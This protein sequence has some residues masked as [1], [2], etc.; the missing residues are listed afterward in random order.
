M[1]EFMNRLRTMIMAGLV[2]SFVVS[3]AREAGEKCEEAEQ[4]KEGLVCYQDKCFM[5][6]E[7]GAECTE[8]EA[9]VKGLVC[10]QEK[11]FK[12]REPG[13][14]CADAAECL[15]GL[16]CYR[17]KCF[18]L[19][20]PGAECTDAAE[21]REG[22][23]CYQDKCFKLRDEGAD[24]AAAGEC[25]E[26]LVCYGDKC[27]KLRETGADCADAGACLEGLVCY[28]DK[29]FELREAGAACAEAGECKEGLVCYQDKCF[30]RREAGAECAEA[31]ECIEGL[32]CNKGKCFKLRDA[33]GDCADGAECVEG[34]VCFDGR[35]MTEEDKVVA[36]KE[37]KE[38]EA[39]AK[40]V[41]RFRDGFSPENVKVH[42]EAAALVAEGTKEYKLIFKR[43]KDGKDLHGEFMKTVEIVEQISKVAGEGKMEEL[44]ALTAEGMALSFKGFAVATNKAVKHTNK[45]RYCLSVADF[46]CAERT[47][48]AAERYLAVRGLFESQYDLFSASHLLLTMTGP[49]NLR[50]I[51]FNELTAR[52]QIFKEPVKK[53]KKDARE[54]LDSLRG[55][56]D[57]ALTV[58]AANEEDEKEKAGMEAKLVELGIR[59]E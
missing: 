1:R 50:R 35:C 59:K 15:E 51:G 8:A 41:E 21:C 30:Q 23:V 11:C 22:L 14:E 10:H 31:A 38:K 25:N 4:C 53:P 18:A 43:L 7:A 34:L 49:T 16:V 56:I 45:I 33:G 24:C 27:F 48:I 37:K 9:C 40:T 55:D 6:G 57:A 13:A 26:G 32:V 20:E 2:V 54:V 44:P 47:S 39:L 3:C 58:S 17:A 19:R 36:V 46:D 52:Y 28:R 12:L 29:C 42:R 5:L